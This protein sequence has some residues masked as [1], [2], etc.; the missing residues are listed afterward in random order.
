MEDERSMFELLIYPSPQP[1]PAWG[2]DDWGLISAEHRGLEV[3]FS[4]VSTNEGKGCVISHCGVKQDGCGSATL[5]LN[6]NLFCQLNT[7]LCDPDKS[8]CHVNL[9]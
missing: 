9:I 7:E 2:Q 8:L 3:C 6:S 1:C 4:V 5:Y